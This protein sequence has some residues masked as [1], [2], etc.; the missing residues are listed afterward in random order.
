MGHRIEVETE[1][2]MSVDHNLNGLISQSPTRVYNINDDSLT[3]EELSKIE[4]LL[5]D[6]VVD[7]VCTDR[8][9]LLNLY[10]I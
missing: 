7:K 3:Q 6:P 5:A 10:D 2:S 8:P 1:G 4:K 9:F